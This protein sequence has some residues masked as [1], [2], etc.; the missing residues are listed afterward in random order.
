M[1]VAAYLVG[2]FLIASVYAAAMLRGRTDRYHRLGFVIAVHR[3][4]DRDADPDGRR[5][6]AGPLGVQQPAG[7]SSPRSS[8]CPRPQ[9]RPRD[10]ARPAQLRRHRQRRDPDPRP[11]VLAVR[12]E[13]R[14]GHGRAG[15]ATR[16][17]ADDRPTDLRGQRRAPRAGTSWS[18]SA[19]CCSCSRSGTA[20]CWA[21]PAP[22]CRAD[23]WFLRV[24][25]ACGR[26]RRGHHGGR[27]GGD[28]GRPAALDRL[29]PHEGRGRGDR[30]TPACGSRSSRRRCSTSHWGSPRSSCCAR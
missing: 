23:R 2:G 27:L 8:W 11:G 4:R 3:R 6:R 16:V 18:G 25:A 12:P 17:P 9:R 22:A 24:A 20:P 19:R 14:Q 21:V 1:V 5:R 7:R 26:A 28:R 15:P 30:R 10:A 13:H 29:Q